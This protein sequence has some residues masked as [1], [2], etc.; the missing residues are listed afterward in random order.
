MI[1][2]SS[3]K[4]CKGRIIVLDLHKDRDEELDLNTFYEAELNSEHFGI[5][6]FGVEA[7]VT[8]FFAIFTS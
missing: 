8:T 7:L 2:S 6:M 5:F 3:L 4:L 1:S